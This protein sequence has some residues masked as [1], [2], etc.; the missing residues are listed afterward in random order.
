TQT[1]NFTNL[2]NKTN[3][4]EYDW[5][6]TNDNDTANITVNKSADIKVSQSIDSTTVN[7]NDFVKF[8][9]NVYNNGPDDAHD[10]NITDILPTGIIYISHSVDTG[11]YNPTTGIWTIDSLGYDETASL[12][13]TTKAI[14][15]GSK[16]NWANKTN[17]TE[18]D[19]NKT[20]NGADVTITVSDG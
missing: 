7:L 10:I 12:N 14:E 1:G 2:A 9:I 8:M 17:E 3:E 6:K 19:W 16:T 11:E 20:N 4:T 15:T 18:Y 13:I 5:N